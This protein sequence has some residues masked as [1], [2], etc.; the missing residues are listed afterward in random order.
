MRRWLLKN[1][2]SSY[3]PVGDLPP[4]LPATR[5]PK[6][7]R[8]GEKSRTESVRG[9]DAFHPRQTIITAP[10]HPTHP[11]QTLIQP[12]APV[13]P[14]KILPALPNIVQLAASAPARPKL[15]LTSEQLT[16][17]RPKLPALRPASDTDVPQVDIAAKQLGTVPIAPSAQ[18]PAKPALQVNP[19]VRPRA[20]CNRSQMFTASCILEFVTPRGRCC[21]HLNRPL[22]NACPGCATRGDS[23]GKSVSTAIDFT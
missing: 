1:E 8:P 20:R 17:V 14:P 15:E 13:S 22:G 10:L 4:I 11:R 7:A 2:V 3:P 16:A 18:A 9:A 23:S 6:S 19:D 21:K 12:A 5:A